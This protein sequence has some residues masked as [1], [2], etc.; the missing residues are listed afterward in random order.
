[1][2]DSAPCQDFFGGF[3]HN[4]LRA[5]QS[6]HLSPKS[7]NLPP[8]CALLPQNRSFNH[9]YFTLKNYLR[10]FVS[11]RENKKEGEIFVL[12][13]CIYILQSADGVFTKI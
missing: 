7:D 11:L 13:N 6:A 2:G 5:L 4:A 12:V 1:M 9:I 3:V 10:T 8:K